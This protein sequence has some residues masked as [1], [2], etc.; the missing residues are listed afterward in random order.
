MTRAGGGSDDGLVNCCRHRFFCVILR[1]VLWWWACAACHTHTRPCH[2]VCGQH[3]C[4]TCAGVIV[5][6][7]TCVL[8]KN[9]LGSHG[10]SV[11]WPCGGWLGHARL[12]C[13]RVLL[14]VVSVLTWCA[15]A[16]CG[17]ASGEGVGHHRERA[18]WLCLHCH[19]GFSWL[20][21]CACTTT[22]TTTHQK[23]SCNG[24]NTVPSVCVCMYLC[25]STR[26]VV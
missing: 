15:E 16:R 14:I 24:L 22:T 10:T 20:G 7:S 5:K 2:S 9:P 26:C 1:S 18:L 11:H 12:S 19:N 6:A 3:A 4:S 17:E 25:R 21:L 8:G 13:A 23:H